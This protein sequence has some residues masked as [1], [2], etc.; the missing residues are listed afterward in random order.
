M[1]SIHTKFYPDGSLRYIEFKNIHG[2]HRP[3]GPSYL[4]W[5]TNG[6]LAYQSYRINE[7]WNNFFDTNT[8]LTI[9]ASQ[10]WYTNGQ[11]EYQEYYVD[12]KRNNFFNH[13]TNKTIPAFQYWSDN[14]QLAYQSY[15][16]NDKRNNFFDKNT[17]LTIP[18]LQR[19]YSDGQ[20]AYQQYY[21]N[22]HCISHENFATL[23]H[24]LPYYIKKYLHKIHSRNKLKAYNEHLAMQE[25]IYRPAGP[26]AK[27]LKMSFESKTK[28]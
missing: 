25:Y 19:W 3:D 23:Y 11:L 14:G 9:P 6:Q 15:F 7:K 8:N 10:Q 17:N 13:E 21:I 5:H 26:T 24:I 12:N 27:D 20:P 4:S 28:N 1:T 18:A 2:F 22:N 16:I